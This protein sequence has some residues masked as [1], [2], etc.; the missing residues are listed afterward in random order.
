MPSPVKMLYCT[1][2]IDTVQPIS[3]FLDYRSFLQGTANLTKSV[4]H[5]L[6]WSVCV[7]GNPCIVKTH[8]NGSHAVSQMQWKLSIYH[9]YKCIITW[10]SHTHT[11]WVLIYTYT[12]H[13]DCLDFKEALVWIL[14]HHS[15]EDLCKPG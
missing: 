14:W 1:E 4:K 9:Q 12:I 10:H 3:C 13:G 15:S 2:N 11:E 6:V 8:W 7:A 5:G